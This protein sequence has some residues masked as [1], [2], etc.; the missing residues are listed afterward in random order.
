MKTDIRKSLRN[1]ARGSAVLAIA[2]IAVTAPGS[3]ANAADVTIEHSCPGWDVNAT[4]S[5]PLGIFFDTAHQETYVADTG[6]RQ[7]VVCDRNGIPLYRFNH[8]VTG[9]NGE[10]V[11]GEPKSIAVDAAGRIFVV[12]GGSDGIGVLD[13]TGR[14]ISNIRPPADECGFP[15]SFQMLALGPDGIYAVLSCPKRRVAVIDA[16]LNIDRVVELG[17]TD[18]SEKAC[19]TGLA[20]DA[21]GEIYVTDACASEMVQMYDAN[22]GL[23]RSFGAHDTGLENFSFAS[24]IA[25]TGDGNMWIVDTLRHVVSLFTPEGVRLTTV[26]GKGVEPGSLQYPSSVAT[27]GVGR[28]FVAERAG[29]RYQCYR[30]EGEVLGSA[31][32]ARGQFS[33]LREVVSVQNS[34][35]SD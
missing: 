24:G 16:E 1:S 6:N 29:N 14:S 23:L 17:W 35:E 15:E 26:G 2:W 12:A 4:F 34:R 28:V 21:E 20:V 22:G 33:V 32:P 18:R 7:I 31:L 30:L 5:R 25:L 9:A 3:V 8:F 27:D 13:A 10:A 19:I 11:L